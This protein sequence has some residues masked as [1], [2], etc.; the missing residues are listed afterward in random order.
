MEGPKFTTPHPEQPET[1]DQKLVR[2]LRLGLSNQETSKFL[3]EWTIAQERA[4]EASGEGNLA[5]INF[6]LKRARLYFEA[7]YYSEAFENF[8]DAYKQAW[9]EGLDELCN[10]IKIE[11]ETL[12]ASLRR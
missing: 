10:Q 3:I 12:E 1:E 5:Q 11:S 4:V 9:Q 8:D 2:L 6:N 7:G